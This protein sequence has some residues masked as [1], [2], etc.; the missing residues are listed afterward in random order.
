MKNTF[1]EARYAELFAHIHK[2]LEDL[3]ALDYLSAGF[4]LTGGAARIEGAEALADSI[5]GKD[6]TRLG[7]PNIRP[8]LGGQ[9]VQSS[10]YATSVGLLIAGR[11]KMLEELEKQ[12][13]KRKGINT[14]GFLAKFRA[15]LE[16]NLI[17]NM[18][19][20]R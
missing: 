10:V 1:I 8:E 17:C 19:Y 11:D 5:F 12:P 4:V 2:Q 6:K 14:E 20:K 3:G 13:T 18:L 15:W 7:T 9:L 16:R